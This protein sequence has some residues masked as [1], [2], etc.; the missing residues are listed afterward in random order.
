MD[1]KKILEAIDENEVLVLG[2]G[3]LGMEAE[4]VVEKDAQFREGEMGLEIGI[5]SSSGIDFFPVGMFTRASV[6]KKLDF[7]LYAMKKIEAK[8]APIVVD[9]MNQL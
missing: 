8:N 9:E 7:A 6:M 5:E 2:S 1:I 4:A 3:F